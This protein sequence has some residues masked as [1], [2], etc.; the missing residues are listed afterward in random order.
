[1]HLQPPQGHRRKPFDLLL[2]VLEATLLPALRKVTSHLLEDLMRRYIYSSLPTS[3]RISVPAASAAEAEA[4]AARLEHE[5][6]DLDSLAQLGVQI[7]EISFGDHSD[8]ELAE[9]GEYDASSVDAEAH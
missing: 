2:R 1:M 5:T 7:E 9:E 3:V 6:H 4:L 8:T